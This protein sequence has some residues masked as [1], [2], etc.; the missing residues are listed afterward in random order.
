LSRAWE[1]AAA[2]LRR[3]GTYVLRTS[4][5]GTVLMPVPAWKLRS[6]S[7]KDMLELTGAVEEQQEPV[8]ARADEL[9][10]DVKQRRAAAR[11][12]RRQAKR[13]R[14]RAAA[15]QQKQGHDAG[16]V[17]HGG[18]APAPAATSDSGSKADTFD[19]DGRPND[20]TNGAAQREQPRVDADANGAA[21]NMSSGE[22]AQA[23]PPAPEDEADAAAD[24]S[25]CMEQ[26]D[27]ALALAAKR[28]REAPAV[29]HHSNSKEAGKRPAKAGKVVRIVDLSRA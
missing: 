2:C 23:Q 13:E 16:Q 17:H 18:A 12:R 21:N 27:A 25:E 8:A 26:V 29:T 19:A 24:D 20:A 6:M 14:R 3:G 28:S 10:N 4:P 9:T 7:A 1:E 22:T 5:T 15:Q 11:K